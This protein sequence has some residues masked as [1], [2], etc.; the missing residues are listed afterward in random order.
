VQNAKIAEN[1]H[2]FPTDHLPA[3]RN[4]LSD[5][6][7][8]VSGVLYHINFSTIDQSTI[9][10]HTPSPCYDLIEIVKNLVKEFRFLVVMV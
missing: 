8:A 4:L 9:I 5:Q 2:M 1:L 10:T 3:L 7:F 6:I